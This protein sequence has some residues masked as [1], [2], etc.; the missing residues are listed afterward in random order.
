MSWAAFFF[1]QVKV[2][3]EQVPPFPTRAWQI[4]TG[5]QIKNSAKTN[6][7]V[8][9]PLLIKQKIANGLSCRAQAQ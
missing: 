5:A 8:F 7:H 3:G 6:T 9:L 1:G 4:S 2:S